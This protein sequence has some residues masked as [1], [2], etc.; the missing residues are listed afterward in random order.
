MQEI[1]ST[2]LHQNPSNILK[3]ILKRKIQ[4]NWKKHNSI[5]GGGPSKGDQNNGALNGKKLTK[6]SIPAKIGVNDEPLNQ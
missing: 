6:K 1:S 5:M 2:F 4:L 3:I